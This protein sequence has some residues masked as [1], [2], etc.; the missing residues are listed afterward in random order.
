MFCTL[1]PYG[2]QRLETATQHLHPPTHTQGVFISCHSAFFG[3]RILT[4]KAA[5]SIS[6]FD[7]ISGWS[8]KLLYLIQAAGEV[9]LTDLYSHN[10]AAGLCVW[11][12][13]KHHI[14]I[15]R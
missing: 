3:H 4:S 9:M 2:A 15:Q 11:L 1:S 13:E 5:V 8:K 6:I 10:D 12:T 7:L 14:Y